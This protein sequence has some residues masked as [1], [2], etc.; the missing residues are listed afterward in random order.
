MMSKK[1]A[2]AMLEEEVKDDVKESKKRSKTA[3]T[4]TNEGSFKSPQMPSIP[5]RATTGMMNASGR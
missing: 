5:P 2:D 1:Y 4:A 3:L